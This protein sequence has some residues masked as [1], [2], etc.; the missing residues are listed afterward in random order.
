MPKGVDLLGQRFTRLL[1]L[2]KIPSVNGKKLL[3]VC[4]CDCGKKSRVPSRSL[5][6]ERARSCGCLGVDLK[7]KHH[8]SGTLF[9]G[10]WTDMKRRCYDPR[11]QS[12]K[13]Y[14]GRGIDVCQEWLDN[15]LNFKIDM[16]NDYREGL[17]IER[18]D[19]NKGYCK[20]N[21]CWATMKVQSRNQ[22]RNVKIETPEGVMVLKDA[23]KL[24]G[25]SAAGLAYRMRTGV[26]IENLFDP[27]RQKRRLL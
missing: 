1:V 16:F 24:Y 25:L 7:T 20:D 5:L 27:S 12:Y 4:Q 15:Y 14:G 2:E 26:P 3:W 8:D 17:T 19:V 11:R 23:A 21:C 9:Y 22:R 6:T 10:V 13:N 18:V